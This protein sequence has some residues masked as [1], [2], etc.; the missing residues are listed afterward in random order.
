MH[1]QVV[2][3]ASIFTPTTWHTPSFPQP[4]LAV[5]HLLPRRSR[6][7]SP[8]PRRAQLPLERGVGRLQLPRLLR[9]PGQLLPHPPRLPQLLLQPLHLPPQGLDLLHR[10]RS[11]QHPATTRD[12]HR[13]GRRGL[14]QNG[15]R[16]QEQALR[17]C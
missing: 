7:L 10:L 9:D 4:H 13:S 16:E 6:L 11:R 17:G 5:H 1:A 8:V 3:G 14:K 2:V 15:E 12:C